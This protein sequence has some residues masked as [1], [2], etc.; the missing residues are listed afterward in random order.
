[1]SSASKFTK[2]WQSEYDDDVVRVQRARKWCRG[3]E[4]GQTD[5]RDDDCTI[6]PSISRIDMN[7]T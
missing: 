2:N 5:I 3:L 7:E 6:W 4:S 1:M